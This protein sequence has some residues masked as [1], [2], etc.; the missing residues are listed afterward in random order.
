MRELNSYKDI[1]NSLI[2]KVRASSPAA[3]EEMLELY[4]PLITSFVTR[5]CANNVNKQDAEDLRQ[6]LT[7]VFYN[8]I[9]S[10]DLE[11]NEVSFGLYAKICMNNA[12]VTQLRALKKRNENSFVSLQSDDVITRISGEE[13]NPEHDLIEREAVKELKTRIESL[14]SSFENKVW[15]LY[16]AGCTSREMAQTLGK[17]EKSIDNAVFRI[18]R[19]LKTLFLK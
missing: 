9:L 6:E 7:V 15:R 11:Q 17:S 1:V 16:V 19:K 3:F 14:L 12:L 13:D 2:L 4:D 8:S 18:R 10:F 5:F